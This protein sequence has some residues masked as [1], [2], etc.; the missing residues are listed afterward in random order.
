MKLTPLVSCAS[1]V[2]LGVELPSDHILTVRSR[3]AEANVFGS[4]GFIA[5][6]IT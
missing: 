2:K 4:L 3:H 5:I 6:P 1:R